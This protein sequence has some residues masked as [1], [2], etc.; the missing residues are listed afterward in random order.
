MMVRTQR[1]SPRLACIACALLAALLGL[2]IARPVLA[3]TSPGAGS[4]PQA[5][6]AAEQR[7][8]LSLAD[9]VALALQNNPQ[10][11]VAFATARAA[12]AEYG[13]ARGRLFPTINAS[14]PISR[15]HGVSGGTGTTS[16]TGTGT[17]TDTTGTGGTGAR[18][19]GSGDRTTFTPGLTLSY[20]LF[21]FG[22]R[23]GTIDAA[24]QAAA[25]ASLQGDVTTQSVVLQ[26]ESAFFSYNAARDLAEAER[27]NVGMSAEARDA[28]VARFRAGLATVAD[29]LQAS[30][31]LA[32][33]QLDLLTAQG[34]VQT[35]RGNLAAAMGTSADVPFQ[36]EATGATSAVAIVGGSVDSLM[37]RAVRER[38]DLA[39]ARAQAA[40][41]EAQ[42]RVA[43]SALLPSLT[44]SSNAGH[45]FSDQPNSSGNTY[46]VSLGVQVPVFSGRSRQYDVRAA[47]AELDAAQARVDVA[48]VNV[49]NQV[50]T[51]YAGLQ[52]AGGRVRVS[53]ELL[54]SAVLSEQV[55]RG[56]YAEGVGSFLDL[57]TAQQALADARA[58]AAQAR[59][60]WQT[61]LAQ[62]AHDVG[63][64]DTAG[65]TGLPLNTGN[66]TVPEVIR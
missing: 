5:T 44:V 64:L 16:G 50:F 11:R 62:L 31:A 47:R 45:T 20:L 24:R 43:R 53:Q 51:S 14:A 2:A 39:A 40:G 29:T 63:T 12:A 42:V 61:A 13:S 34:Q 3:Q 18:A 56:R 60:Q 1:S 26:A 21:D 33:S 32:R 66:P 37:A 25:A 58:Q 10:T 6:A 65:A 28:T 59:W 55:A 9:V 15:T 4:T 22:G 8:P 54:A 36:V 48:R 41:A 23:S 30:T 46:G 38:P 7:S 27:A 19:G 35:A 52:V 49:A 17:G 57:L